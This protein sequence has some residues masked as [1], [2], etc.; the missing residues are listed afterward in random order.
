MANRPPDPKERELWRTAMRDAKP[1]RKGK[2]AKPKVVA[3]SSA[4]IRT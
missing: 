4:R 1:L 3:Y 2:T